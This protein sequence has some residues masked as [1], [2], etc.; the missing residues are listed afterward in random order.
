[1]NGPLL[2]GSYDFR[3]VA[4]SVAI[5]I[6]AAYAALDL[7]GR[8]T[9]SRGAMRLSWLCGGAFAFGFGIWAMHYVGMEAF[10]LPVP[11]LY[12]WPMVL[13]SMAAAV[14]SS[15]IALYIVS[16]KTMGVSAAAFGALLMGSGIAAMHY[17]GME[18]MRLPAM[19]HYSPGL[20]AVSV[21]LAVVISF[22][23]L[24]LSFALRGETGTKWSW[25][26]LGVAI[27]MG[28]AI[29]TMHYVGMAA[30]SYR[31]DASMAADLSHTLSV[32]SLG[33]AGIVVTTLTLLGIVFLTATL[34]RHF[35]FQAAQ[36]ELSQQ[37]IRMM[38]ELAA[39]RDKARLAEASSKA[40]SEFLANMSHEIRTPLNG[41][42]GMTDLTLETELTREQREY[43]ETVK[44]SADALLN[45]INDIL[46]FSK[47]EAGKVDLDAIDFDF[48]E[49]IEGVLKTLA[50]RAD[51]KGLELLCDITT[52]IP[53]VVCGDPGRLRQI[54]I[55]LL[56]NALKF[57]SEGEVSLKVTLDVVEDKSSLVHFV[58]ADTGVGIPTAKMK[59]IFDAFSQADTST[60]RQ[61]GGT[62]LGLTISRRLVEMMGG[63]LWVESEVGV[64]SKFHF[65]V[66]L[67]EAQEQPE[68]ASATGS[69]QVLDGVKVLVVDDN[70]TNRRI[71][72]G[73]LK[74]WRMF[75]TTVAE[76]ELAL[77]EL[78]AAREAGAPY[79][80]VLTDMHMPRMDGFGLVE[81]IHRTADLSTATIMM[82]TS[83]GHRGDA[84]RCAELG[85]AAYL[86]KPVRQSEL[87]E[88]IARVL[89]RR[90]RAGEKPML[91]R[92]SLLE[93]R[94]AAQRLHILLAEDNPV[95]QKL[96]LRL[97][98]KRGH[99]VAVAGNGS[100]ALAALEK[101]RFDL[102]LMDVQMPEMDGLEATIE[103]RRRET[104][105]GRHT[106][107]VA[108]T[109]LAMKGDKERCL[110]AGMD[111]YLSKPIR[112]EEL[113]N[114]LDAYT[115][116]NK[117]AAA[118]PE[119]LPVNESV[120]VQELLERVDGDRG[121]IA[122]L[123]EVFREDYPRQMRAAREA[124]AA[125]DAE[126]VRRAGHALKGAL[127][128]LAAAR[129]CEFAFALETMGRSGDLSGAAL[130]LTQLE[131]ELP[132]VEKK[133]QSICPEMVG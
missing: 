106:P 70:R 101:S 119:A 123:A 51:E 71:L 81:S 112:P 48:C 120:D 5:A 16:R 108:M 46:D 115:A 74:H 15:G 90:D 1:M 14:V 29:P 20:V 103:L 52:E 82:L 49:C 19:C 131:D 44:L 96:A 33:L 32:S 80:L 114:I 102:V 95:N 84:A 36:L 88:A 129:A 76:A 127:S 97:L 126:K 8:V 47:I 58:V 60:T 45:V 78:R 132:R 68:P 64:G 92:Y 72:D 26:K 128:N 122:E 56:G 35:T 18:A 116:Q 125:G 42:I 73:L 62:G 117:S 63:R 59:T 65:T 7:A 91:T 4:L 28:L 34:D 121:F 110:E 31:A 38:E 10:N 124:A 98:Q 30:V 130:T 54:L 69:Q 66:R 23:A 100:E 77:T 83:G 99:A 39:E 109:A 61:F 41:I 89:T 3:L 104:S 111:G 57:T 79:D 2:T 27:L 43:L 6:L 94:S 40:K 113:D 21:I 86:L 118:Q 25:R 12:N 24:W 11:V 75:P 55:N 53:E 85:I 22:V 9:A 50:L 107:V 67:G 133:L 93:E 17:I 13:L 105:S 87:R 37:R